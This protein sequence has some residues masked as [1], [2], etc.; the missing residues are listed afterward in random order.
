MALRGMPSNSL[1]AVFCAITMPPASLMART[2][3]VP[4]LPVPESTM[5][6]ANSR[7]SSA[8]DWK[9]KSIGK[10]WP[11][12]TTGSSRCSAPLQKCHV[13]VGRDDVGAVDLDRHAVFHLKHLHAGVVANQLAEHAFVVG[14]PGAA[15]AQRPCRGLCRR[16]C[17][18]RRPQT[19]PGRRRKHR[20]RRWGMW[21]GA[22]AWGRRALTWGLGSAR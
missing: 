6:M 8:R 1:D 3:R 13:V 5:P 12:G 10:R 19:P 16:A 11:R 4:S 18:R 22:L 14:E 7:W 17:R 15:P 2:P 9:K 20:C 21:W